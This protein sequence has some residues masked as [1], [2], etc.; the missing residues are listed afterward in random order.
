MTAVVRDVLRRQPLSPAKVTFAWR[1]A[2]GAPLARVTSA[3]LEGG[4]L[5]VRAADP[6]WRREVQRSTS[7]LLERLAALLGPD[8]VRRIQMEQDPPCGNR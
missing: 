6:R 5:R 4:V 3:A 1:L 7:L 2:V 8:T